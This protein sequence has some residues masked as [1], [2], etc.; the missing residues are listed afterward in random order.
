MMMLSHAATA[1]VSLLA[2]ALL[3][4]AMDR[5]QQTLFGRELAA[6]R[7]RALRIGGWVALI[8]SLA[9]AVKAQGWALGLVAWCGHIG[10]GA[11]LVIL[12]LIAWDRRRTRQTRR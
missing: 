11:G 7:T 12:A 10:L 6:G 4:L 1:A 2:F 5:P 3:A 8:A 9:I